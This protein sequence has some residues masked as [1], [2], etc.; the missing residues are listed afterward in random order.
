MVILGANLGYRLYPLQHYEYRET[1]KQKISLD[2]VMDY[3]NVVCKQIYIGMFVSR[4]KWQMQSGV[5]SGAN[6]LYGSKKFLVVINH[7]Q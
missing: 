4:T 7:L 2:I 1:N 3:I 6:T 5:K